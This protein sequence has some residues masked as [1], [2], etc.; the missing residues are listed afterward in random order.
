[1]HILALILLFLVASIAAVCN[2]DFSGLA[3]CCLGK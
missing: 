2:G 3:V 1:M